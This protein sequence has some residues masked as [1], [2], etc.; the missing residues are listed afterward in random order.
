MVHSVD[1]LLLLLLVPPDDGST[2]LS[3]GEGAQ[4]NNA[5]ARFPG[6]NRSLVS[7]A[8]STSIDESWVME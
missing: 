7:R 3:D 6:K 8:W 2:H 4:V 1:L 5:R